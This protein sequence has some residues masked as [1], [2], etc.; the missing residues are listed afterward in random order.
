MAQTY[1]CTLL[2]S[3]LERHPRV[4]ERADD[5]VNVVEVPGDQGTR[6]VR[7]QERLAHCAS[8]LA[9]G[10]SHNPPAQSGGNARDHAAHY[11]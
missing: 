1:L 5:G 3:R 9:A 11:Q 8:R 10:P 4:V 7:V 6:Q 2:C